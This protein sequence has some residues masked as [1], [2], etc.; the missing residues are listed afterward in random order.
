[1]QLLNGVIPSL[2]AMQEE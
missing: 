2:E 1:M